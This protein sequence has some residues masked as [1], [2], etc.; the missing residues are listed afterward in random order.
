MPGLTRTI[1]AGLDRGLTQAPGIWPRLD[2]Q[3]NPG[4]PWS[5]YFPHILLY[6]YIVTR[7]LPGR[8]SRP[9][10]S[11]SP[12]P[13]AAISKQGLTAAGHYPVRAFGLGDQGDIAW[14]EDS[15]NSGGWP[16]PSIHDS[17]PRFLCIQFQ[18]YD[19]RLKKRQWG[20]F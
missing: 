16:G 9:W 20:G 15:R 7:W 1:W 12:S 6:I 5:R 3:A 13:S 11:N 18:R 2:T 19:T 17:S 8:P 14:K 4:Y 10:V